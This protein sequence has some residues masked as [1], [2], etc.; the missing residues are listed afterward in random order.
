MTMLRSAA[1]VLCVTDVRTMLPYFQQQ[2]GFEMKGSAGELPS[3]ASMQRDSV[4]I[5]LVCGDYPA[6]ASDWAVYLYVEDA[7]ALYRELKE[8]GADLLAEPTDKPYGCREFEVRLPDGRLLAF[9][10]DLTT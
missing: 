10:A 9:G 4:E 2:L 5:M 8:R 6:P 7:D 3:W 1:P